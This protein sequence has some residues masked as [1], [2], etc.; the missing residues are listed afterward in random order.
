MAHVESSSRAS[1]DG[2]S[3]DQVLSLTVIAAAKYSTSSN[4]QVRVQK[5]HTRTLSCTMTVDILDKQHGQDTSSTAFL[6]LFD[7]RFSTQLR[8]DG[9][10]DPWTEGM[11]GAYQNMVKSGKIDQFL[12]NLREVEG[13]QD[14]TEEDWDD[15]ENEAFLA[16]DTLKLFNTEV[17]VYEA[18]RCHQ[19]ERI[20]RLLAT[21]ELDINPNDE[22][23]T[24]STTYPDFEPYKIKGMLLQ[25]IDGPDL[26][27]IADHFPLSTWQRIVDKAVSSVQILGDHNI[28]NRDVRPDN[29]VVAATSVD[30][31]GTPQVFMIDFAL[32]RFRGP[33]E[34]DKEWGMAKCTKDEEGAVGLLMKKYL[35]KRG[36]ELR[37]ESSLRYEEWGDTDV[38]FLE[39]AIGKEIRPGVWFYTRGPSEHG[40]KH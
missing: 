21:V 18:L 17:Q 24:V 36:F 34:S 15:G 9:G 28:L 19:G 25:H 10:I 3:S 37:Y 26:T 30:D 16:D 4:M 35:E 14:A 1:V 5:T 39:N 12:H 22:L 40:K 6:K 38:S 11:E 2:Y 27:D 33:E 32:C 7:R 29:F 20:P 13:F 31:D 8:R 23:P